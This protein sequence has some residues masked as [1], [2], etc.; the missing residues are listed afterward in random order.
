MI[1]AITVQPENCVLSGLE[2]RKLMASLCINYCLFNNSP[3][4]L[5]Q[6]DSRI[7][8]PMHCKHSL[9]IYFFV[10]KT[11]ESLPAPLFVK[12]STH[13][14]SFVRLLCKIKTNMHMFKNKQTKTK[15]L[16]AFFQKYAHQPQKYAHSTHN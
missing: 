6:D 3:V 7:W 16:T 5:Q 11:I 4:K 1:L 8:V 13:R 2:L 9:C 14:H 10:L 12:C 15:Q